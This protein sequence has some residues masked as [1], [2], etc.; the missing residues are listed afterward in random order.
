MSAG[1]LKPAPAFGD[2]NRAEELS[3]HFDADNVSSWPGNT[4]WRKRCGRIRTRVPFGRASSASSSTCDA[5]AA[6]A[7]VGRLR[8]GTGARRWN[9][10]RASVV[11]DPATG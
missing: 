6:S 10:P 1:K 7:D 9:R 11:D 3:V 8:R 4:S 5:G 2:S